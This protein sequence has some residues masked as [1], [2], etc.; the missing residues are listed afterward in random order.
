MVNENNLRLIGTSH[1]SLESKDKIKAE[2]LDF[3]PD[4]ICIELDKNRY[5]ALSNPDVKRGKPSIKQLGMTGYLF[6]VIGR[7]L[8]KKL[9]NLTG[10]NPGD[11]ML[12]GAT[13][14]RQ[15]KL[16]LE[17]IDQDA[18]LTMRNMSK[19]VKFSEKMKIVLDVF[20]SPF[21]KKMR[22]KI[23][24]NKIPEDEV[25]I[26]ILTL[27][28]DRYPGFYRVLIDDRNSF[29]A[30]KIYLLMKDNPDKRV[31]AIVGAG[32]IDGM[33]KKLKTLIESNVY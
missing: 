32:H 16:K 21:S 12:M 9:G 25:I 23:D 10:M 28:K 22:L 1:I 5:Y 33:R 3:K 20:I 4:I 13:L 29:M 24:I 26:R 11:E 15:N 7:V 27:M 17:L 8:Q 31:M 18:A 6:A 14:A 2:F 19:K 30:K